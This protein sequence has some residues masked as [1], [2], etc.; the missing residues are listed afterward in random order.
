MVLNARDAANRGATI[1]TR[2]RAVSATRGADGWTLIAEDRRTGKTV[3]VRAR[4]LVNAGG[5]WV[6]QVLAATLK[7]NAS[8]SVRLVQGSHIVVRKLYDHDRCYIFQNADDRIIFAIPFERDFTLIGTT[9][10]DYEGDPASVAATLEEID[11]LCRAASAYFRNPIQRDDVVWTYSGVR[12]LYD[13]GASEAQAATR[14]YVLVLDD[15]GG[16]PLLSIYGGKLTTYRRLAEHAL[17]RLAPHLPAAAM[18]ARGWSGSAPLPG[19][20]FAPQ[21]F[22]VLVG[23][24]QRAYPWLAAAHARRLCRLYGTRARVILQGST[25]FSSLGRHFGA[26]LTEAEID[27]VMRQEWAERAD[28]VV[29]RRTKLGLRLTPDQIS[30][31]DAFMRERLAAADAA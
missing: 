29:W 15:K 8:A 26:T 21:N 17:D 18:R 3:S 9:D 10:R 4:V 30:A 13:D 23:E 7:M 6:G 2:T 16:A 28:D 22:A 19:G 24:M 11:Y 12:P 5:P 20:D 14:D 1:R 31:I 27:Y 25:G